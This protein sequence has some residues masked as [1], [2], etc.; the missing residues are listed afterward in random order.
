MSGVLRKDTQ[1]SRHLFRPLDL[2]DI[3]NITLDD[4]IDVIEILL[5]SSQKY[6]RHSDA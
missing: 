1:H 5:L 6:R 3:T 2:R 4:R